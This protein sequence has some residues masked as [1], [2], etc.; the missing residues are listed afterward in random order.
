[1]TELSTG[2]QRLVR[3]LAVLAVAFGVVT[4]FVGGRILLGDAAAR[5]MAGA[6]VGFVLWFNVLAGCAYVV[7][8]VGM[9]RGDRW[10]LGLALAIALLTT[11]VFGAFLAHVQG[12]GAYE[13]RTLWALPFRAAIWFAIAAALWWL[14]GA[15][16][17]R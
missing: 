3:A 11:L 12:G 9:W 13:V 10:S 4:V 14:L 7:A 8:G 2:R 17:G 15:R 16:S 6:Y 1:M 5:Q